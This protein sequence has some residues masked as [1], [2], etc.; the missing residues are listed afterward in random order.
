VKSNTP[1]ILV[2]GAGPGGLAAAMLLAA[3]GA[4]VRVLERLPRV[5]GRTGA[6]ER[7]GFRF[8]MGP[9]FFLYPPILE[10]IF[11][12]CGACLTEEVT[13]RRL[14]PSYD[15]VF[16]NGERIRAT[17]NVTRMQQ[18][19]SRLNPR[20]AKHL[21]EYLRENRAKFS[22]FTPILQRPFLGWRDLLQR[23]T[24]RSLKHLRPWASVD[25]DLRRY[26]EDPRIR[27]AFS[28][29]SKY[30]G[31]SP[32][33]C[34]SLFTILAF[35]E[36]E[37]GVYHPEGGCSAISEAM[38]RQI[39][40]LGGE[41]HLD[42]PVESLSFDGR[43]VTGARTRKGQYRADAVVLNA[44]F[45]HA[46]ENLVPNR[47]RR[48]WRNA[49]LARKRYSCSTFM[50]YLGLDGRYD[51]LAHHSICLTDDYQQNLRDI[52]RNHRIPQNPS[53]YVQ[54]ASVTDRTLAPEGMSTLYCLAPVPH[55]H[56]NIDWLR[57]KNGFRDML[58]TQLEDKLGLSNVRRRICSE[59]LFTPADWSNQLAIYR[60]ATFNLAH[61]LRQML[62]LRPRNRF[63]EID[64]M[65]LVGGGTHPGSGLPVIYESARISA[66]L[67]L[68]DFGLSMPEAPASAAARYAEADPHDLQGL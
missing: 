65:Y 2:V 45:A 6:I 24:L 22:A 46:M 14:D 66:R 51:D 53:F 18:E 47:L 54:N 5:G 31:M 42:E 29:Q 10:E 56:R 52:E 16:D 23:D 44:D 61:N 20:D 19:L 48:R 28:F 57:A 49:K 27:L 36:Y 33:Q 8:D 25:D 1:E 38:A 39:T 43:A 60:G 55:E 63:E 9:T 50:M 41:M 59:L 34:P 12:A 26:F 30:L 7:D 13:L 68:R 37:Y 11:N 58:L 35:L 32:F 15:L 3:G 17:S 40:H 67:V 62:H 64:S 4:R 21:S